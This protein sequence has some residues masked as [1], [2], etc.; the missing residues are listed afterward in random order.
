MHKKHLIG[1]GMMLALLLALAVG[2]TTAQDDTV[3]VIGWE[4]EPPALYPLN[5]LAFSSLLEDFYAREVWEW[6]INRQIFPI[7]VEEIPSFENGLVTTLENGNTQVTYKLREGMLWSD[8]TPITSA[9]CELYHRLYSDRTTSANI[10][11]GLYPDVVESF[12][13]VDDLTFTLTYSRPWPDFLVSGYNR[14]NYPAHV[15]N[16]ILEAEGNI[17][18]APQLISAENV[19]GYGP[20]IFEDWSVG[21]S[22]T[23]VA[24]PNWD[25]VE[26]AIKTVILKPIADASQ[27]K[28][29]LETGEIDLAFNWAQNLAPDYQAI[30]DVEVW[31][32][33]GVFGDAVWINMYDGHPALQDLNVR[34]AIGYAMDRQTMADGLVAPG[35]EIPKSWYSSLW[36]PEDLPEALPYDPDMANQLLDE[37]GWVDSN[38]NGI[39]DKDGVE[40]IL[41]F[42]TTTLQVRMDFQVLIQEYLNAVGIGT[43]LLPVPAS[44]M[45][46]TFANR[47]ITGSRSFDLA[48]FARSADPLSPNV[49]AST[50][51]CAGIAS[52]ETPDGNNSVGYCDEEYDRLARLIESTVDP[53]ERKALVDAAVTRFTEAYFWHGLYLRSTW[54]AMNSA[55]FDVNSARD[56]LGSLSSNYFNQI[57]YWQPAS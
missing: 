13:I 36:W 30:P 18:T 35:T 10:P 43:Q 48:L 8:G 33:P 14:C 54:Y 17:D 38:G 7:M 52:V 37:A 41:R 9:D 23:F 2:V 53:T 45:F 5:N 57:E 1:L 55:R 6:D 11:R 21:E 24:N 39:R 20:Y 4:Q 46:D 22:M 16:P 3:I 42:F 26:P 40:L 28:S 27:M 49:S 47:G 50:F 56:R 19:V 44:I 32:T 15:F 34:K 51:G 31:S 29:A 12:E 25:G